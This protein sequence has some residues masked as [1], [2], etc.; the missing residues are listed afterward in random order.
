MKVVLQTNYVVAE[1]RVEGQVWITC[2]VCLLRA[3]VGI[4]APALLC[5]P[6][7]IDTVFTRVHI[8]T[9]LG[10]IEGRYRAALERWSA[11]VEPH[12]AR[13][14]VVYAARLEMD[15]GAFQAKW[16]RTIAAGGEFAAVLSAWDAAG[17]I[18]QELTERREWAA[19]A[20][21]EI[22]AYEAV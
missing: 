21:E 2:R 7:R 15:E 4:L 3:Q 19:R 16:Q 9:V 17:A 5:N 6:C 12:T 22:E 14:E 8:E 1:N 20:L 10:S 11:L 13:W 18:E